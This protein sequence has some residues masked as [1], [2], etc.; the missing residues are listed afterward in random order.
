MNKKPELL[1]GKSEMAPLASVEQAL[2]IILEKLA[3]IS[4]SEQIDLHHALGRVLAE[5]L[6]SSI[7]V[8]PADN[9]GMDG[10]ALRISDLYPD[11]NIPLPIS[12]RICAGDSV[13]PLKSGTAAR[14]F[15]GA[16]IPIGTDTVVMQEHCRRD[17]DY[18]TIDQLPSPGANIRSAGEDLQSGDIVLTMGS[19]IRPQELGVAA[20]IG[21]TKL[22]V[23]RRL[24]VAILSTGN[25]LINPGEDLKNGKIY[26]SNRYTL[27]GLLQSLDCEILDLGISVDD[28]GII[29]ESLLNAG[30]K[31]DLVLTTGGVS[32][33]EEDHVR[34][35]VNEIGDVELWQLA[36]K[37]GKPVA[38]GNIEGTPFIGLPGNPAAVF[39][40][41]CLLARPVILHLQGNKNI[42]LPTMV[43]RAGFDLQRRSKNRREFLRGRLQSIDGELPMVELYPNQGSGILRSTCW[44]TGFAVVP[45]GQNIARGDLV[46]FLVFNELL[47]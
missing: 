37:P 35:I 15:T 2:D 33:G 21:R 28:P 39:V 9:S 43:A 1:P 17:G 19:R 20:S 45:E 26:N 25:E 42:A 6:C 16:P 46:D 41:F 27:H 32:V 11:N 13:T 4:G 29:R 3:T 7:D 18:V 40:T 23:K 44:A 22:S 5:D 30:Q 14:I 10:Y 8:P 36:I 12:A 31:A 24:C 34:D 47:A 38:Y